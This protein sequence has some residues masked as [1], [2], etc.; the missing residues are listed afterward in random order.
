MRYGLAIYRL[1]ILSNQLRYVP[2]PFIDQLTL[3]FC[4]ILRALPTHYECHFDVLLKPLR[5]TSCLRRQTT[6]TN[7][8]VA[9][10]IN[11]SWTKKARQGEIRSIATPAKETS[12]K[13]KGSFL[14][15][16]RIL[17]AYLIIPIRNL[18]CVF[19]GFFTRYVGPMPRPYQLLRYIIQALRKK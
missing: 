12:S 16:M 8:I 18:I 10:G 3:A 13:Q 5:P 14:C 2:V 6:L 15:S 11:R 7:E 1:R 19:R 4:S 17:A 9:I